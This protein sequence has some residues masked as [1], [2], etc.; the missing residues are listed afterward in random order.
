M[1]DDTPI[2]EEGFGTLH[3]GDVEFEVGGLEGGGG[4][5]AVFA[6]QVADLAGFGVGGVA[7]GDLAAEVGVQVGFG[8]GAGTV[9]WDGLVVDVVDWVVGYVSRV[10]VLCLMKQQLTDGSNVGVRGEGDLRKGPNAA[11]GKPERLTVKTTPVPLELE[12]PDT[13]PRMLVVL[14]LGRTAV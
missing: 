2:A 14:L 13:Y 6:R 3:G 12:V 7:G 5:V 8:A 9:G 1:N 4:D 11:D 10:L